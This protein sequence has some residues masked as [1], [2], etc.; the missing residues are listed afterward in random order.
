[1]VP[2]ICPPSF[3]W[4]TTGHAWICRDIRVKTIGHRCNVA[5]QTAEIAIPRILFADTVRL[6]AGLR[7]PPDPAAA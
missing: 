5:F 3:E 4:Q 1:M 6:I 2:Q 7:P